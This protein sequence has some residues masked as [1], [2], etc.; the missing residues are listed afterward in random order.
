MTLYF[1]SH[2]ISIRRQKHKS[3]LRYGFSSTGTVHSIDLQ[4]MEVERVN[5]AGG[6][7]GKMYDAFL[8]ATVDIKEGDQIIVT[9]TGKVFAVKTVS[10]Y[11][12]AGMLDHHALILVSQD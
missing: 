10:T 8:D 9:D 4:P 11:E 3:G 1:P 2:S 7:I 12:N 5:Q 6:Q